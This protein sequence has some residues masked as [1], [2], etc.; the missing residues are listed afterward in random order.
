MKLAQT[1]SGK[2]VDVGGQLNLIF[3]GLQ[4][5]SPAGIHSTETSEM[6]DFSQSAQSRIPW[7][8]DTQWPTRI[9]PLRSPAVFASKAYSTPSHS[10]CSPAT[11]TSTF[12]RTVP[13]CS[14]ILS[15][16]CPAVSIVFCENPAIAVPISPTDNAVN[17]LR[18][19]IH[20]P[21]DVFILPQ[22]SFK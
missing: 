20:S 6:K 3:H 18:E 7:S 12:G 5:G 10:R 4:N 17:S 11:I 16:T 22:R 8:S 15:I 13:G 14:L 9:I 19:Q 1:S 21:F 2:A